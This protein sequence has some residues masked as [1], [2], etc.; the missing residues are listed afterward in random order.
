MRIDRQKVYESYRREG[1]NGTV[2]AS[3]CARIMTVYES[4]NR[5]T[6]RLFG[7]VREHEICQTDMI[8][9]RDTIRRGRSAPPCYQEAGNFIGIYYGYYGKN[10]R[11][12]A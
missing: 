7:N 4:M 1:K 11:S 10:G 8:R 9:H 6:R 5:A 2:S 3:L 12:T